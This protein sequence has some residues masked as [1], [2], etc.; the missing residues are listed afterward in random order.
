[1]ALPTFPPEVDVQRKAGHYD[2]AELRLAR[3][4]YYGM[5]SE[6]D[7]HVGRMLDVLDET[8]LADETIVVFTSDHGEWL[9]EHL[10][11]GKGYPGHDCVS[12]VPLLMRVPGITGGH[13]VSHLAE[14]VDVVPT[15][16]EACGVPVPPHLQGQSLMALVNGSDQPVKDVALMEFTGWKMVRSCNFRYVVHEE[17]REFLYDLQ[18]PWG[19]YRDVS[20]KTEYRAAL[21]DHRHLL[22]QRLITMERPRKRIW[23]Y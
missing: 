12:R 1:M 9:G 8:G 17:G 20:V 4:G 13:R 15:L 2:D 22:L 14:G 16:L 6:V 10:K 21:A 11:Y 18:A 5:V 3:Q 7:F 23:N 19:E